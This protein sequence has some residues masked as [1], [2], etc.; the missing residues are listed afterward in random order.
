MGRIYK[1]S[2]TG[3]MVRR[4]VR[5][6]LAGL[7]VMGLLYFGG[8]GCLQQFFFNTGYIYKREVQRADELQSYVDKNCLKATDYKQLKKWALQRNIRE[9]TVS[10]DQWLLFDVSYDGILTPG[11]R[12]ITD[13]SWKIFHKI[14]FADGNADVYLYEGFAD[15]YYDILAGTS[16]L[17]GF[18]VCIGIF[19]YEMQED[20]RYIQCLKKE[21]DVITKGN[22]QEHITVTGNDE[23]AQ[24]AGGLEIMRQTLIQ[25]EQ[26]EQELRAAQEK[27]VLGM[28][29][30][31]RTPLT[32]L[33]TYLEILK[34][35]QKNR[36]VTDEYI[37]KSLDKVIQIRNLSD[38]MFEYFFVNSQHKVELEEAEDIFSAFG[39]YLSELCVLLEDEG[40]TVDTEM[41]EWNPA[42]VRI[43][44]DLFGRIMNNIISNIEKYA[45]RNKPIQIQILYEESHIGIL[46]G[47][48]TDQPEQPVHKTG[49]GLQNISVMMEHMHGYVEVSEKE[50]DYCIILYFPSSDS[51]ERKSFSHN[52]NSADR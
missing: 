42:A 18:I 32:G 50:K 4:L 47:N 2:L 12:E 26:S 20:L 13:F 31:L 6:L 46:I 33:M 52:K 21:V 25:K 49:I 14:K 24:L 41:L 51:I 39:D 15:K 11:S 38:Q 7:F 28:S 22:L 30:D 5:G 27:L 44:T 10:R 29:H 48:T 3:K 23:L 16:I 37:Q 34:K 35:Q 1:N 17:V 9:F 45:G 43:N 40:F 36:N 19:S 8:K